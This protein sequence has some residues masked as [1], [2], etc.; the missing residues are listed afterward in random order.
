[1]SEKVRSRQVE[2]ERFSFK[3]YQG[4]YPSPVTWQ[5]DAQHVDAPAV[6]HLLVIG[7]FS[8]NGHTSTATLASI[9]DRLLALAQCPPST[10]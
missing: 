8:H 1:M 5:P 9:P 7:A 4:L 10:K 3:Q 2:K 6:P